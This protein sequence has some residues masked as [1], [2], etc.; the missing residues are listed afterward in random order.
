MSDN[1]KKIG[2]VLVVGGGIGGMQASL[3]LA[4]AGYKVYL[5]EKSPCIGGVMAQLDKTF[6][7]NDCAMCTLAPRIV[8]TGSHLNIDKIT[9]AQI[10]KISGEPGN[11]QV[12]VKKNARYIDL[13]KCTGCSACTDKCPV[14]ISSEFEMDLMKRK[15]IYR[16]YPQAV[17]GAFSIDKK[18]VSPCSFACPAGVNA[19]AYV[20]L[21]GQGRFAEA[22]EVERRKN[23]FP[24][25]C[26]RICPHPCELECARKDVDEAVSI[27]VLKRFLS[28][29]EVS[30]PDKKAP[31]PAIKEKRNEKVAVIGGGPAG[32]MAARELA[33]KGYK[34]TVFE[35]Q[36]EAG[37]MLKYGIPAYR[38]PK[39]VLQ[40]EIKYAVTD[41]GVE[42]KTNQALGKDFTIDDLKKQGYKAIFIGIG[43]WKGLKLSIPGEADYTGV[44]DAVSFLKD[45]N[46]NKPYDVKGKKVA[47]IGGGNVAIDTARS[48]WRLGADVTIVYSRSRAEMPANAWEIEDAVEE[49]IKIVYLAAPA[50][51]LGEGG[52]AAGLECVKMELSESDA[53]GRRRP[54]QVKGSEFTVPADIIIPA[55]SQQPDTAFLAANSE[56]KLNNWGLFEV[57]GIS[58]ETGMTGV[59]AGGDSV[60]GPAT[61]IEAV[62][63]GARAAESIHRYLTGQDL[64]AGRAEPERE[65]VTKD[66]K[67][68]EKKQREHMNK[69]PVSERRGNFKEVEL[70][71]TKEQ[72]I[73]EASRCLSCAG[74]CECMLCVAACEAKAINH[75]MPKEE[76]ISLDVGAV[77]LAPGFELFDA[78]L[79]QEFGFG[80]YPNV[81]SSLQFERV[82]S[83]SGPYIGQILR[84]SDR[85]HPHKIAFIQCVGSREVERNYCSSV[86]CMYAT[87]EAIIAKEHQ[88]DL[89]CHIFYIDIRAF[90]KGFE[91]YYE[92]AKELGVK[93]TRCR[94]SAVREDPKTN[95]LIV[96]YYTEG[97]SEQS[98]VPTGSVGAEKKDEEFD[99]VVLSC[100]LTPPAS[101]KKLGSIF[102][103][104]L[105][106]D[107]F[108]QTGKFTP[109]ETSRPGVFACGPFIEP[110]DIPE[111]VM[112]ACGAASKAMAL[113]A[114][115]RNTLTVK[116]EF[117]P[118]MDVI[119]QEPRIGVFVCH[120]GK[121][122]GGIADVP[123]IRDYAKTL[124]NVVH[125]EDSLYTCSSDTQ[126]KI[127]QMIKEH[128]LNRV[129]VASCTP[130]THEPLFRNTC[131]EAGLN[132]YLFE[133]ANIRD[134]NTWVHM[135]EPAKATRKAKDLVRIAIAKSRMLE[136]L[137]NRSLDVE[138]DALVIGGGLSGMTSALELANQGFTTYLVERSDELGG[139]MKHIYY[140]VE[141][142]YKPQEAL[143]ALAEKVTT[144]PKI[145][146]YTATKIKVIEG[147]MGNFQT[148]LETPEGEVK[149]KHGT[150]IVATGGH[151]YKPKEYLYGEDSM[152]ITQVQ[153]EAKIARK[154]NINPAKL[155]SKSPKPEPAMSNPD[156]DK[157]N[158]VVMI[159]CVGSRDEN[160]PYCSRICCT[161]AVKNALRFK[162]M[163]PEA[164]VYVLYRD[165]RTYGF[166]EEFYRK[167]REAGVIFL[168]YKDTEKPGVA[169]K[170]G[171]LPAGQGLP[172][173]PRSE[174]ERGK[175]TVTLND[176]IL[177]RKVN[178]ETDLVVLSAG[179]V[180][181]P[182]NEEL[183][184]KLKVPLNADKF[185]LEAHM[186]LRPV[187][188]ATEGVYLCGLAHSP[189]NIDESI[190]QAC[191][192]ASR[193]STILAKD[194]I[195]LDA[196]VS[197][198]IDEN[199]DGCAYC[200]DP[201]PYH[202]LTLIE[203]M[204]D[205]AIKKTIDRDLGICK[206]CGVCQ[207][208]CPK[209][210]IVVNNFKLTQL[211]EMVNA[212][213]TPVSD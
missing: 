60:S 84:A 129:V 194:K 51:V 78:N 7:T 180:P 125:V 56:I 119:G 213:L 13:S 160:H 188:F 169:R 16:R 117:P 193:A 34:V 206:G 142:E 74:C 186:K 77:V 164:P 99:M 27:M 202:A 204:K 210:G 199:C 75:E 190:V 12:T 200:V 46:Q 45:V 115:A 166:N 107:G 153:F 203:Y 195:E 82:M 57:D 61:V 88:P 211:I 64:K 2:A 31:L 138:H 55:I 54:V 83:A 149:F 205:G 137:Q 207:A 67:G 15:A 33:T 201:C 187:D 25:I 68:V 76:R 22:L 69:L 147:S 158:S 152:V 171:A 48:A 58:L 63:A 131:R 72:A 168:R 172:I 39:D 59:F 71:Y 120:C 70:G 90:G 136:P 5:T 110:K 6:P 96:T 10:E 23:P 185:F 17:P 122:I 112:E 159:Q 101:V 161:M 154:L 165:V 167:A 86:C 163:K 178:I 184:Q 143:A 26:G 189:K 133:M 170:N 197:Q 53:S 155:P 196:I 134:Q 65:K 191:G 132:P 3:D 109:V 21:A 52:K 85:K 141:E 111:T 144:H 42:L 80:R 192:A 95:N 123:S 156:L 150:V 128:N 29:W 151:E 182:A 18:G 105:N 98:G 135:N 124:P 24:S 118:E 9:D 174:A 113:L 36:A 8:D 81:L 104:D 145:K 50:K 93:Y 198:V 32:L 102:N 37:G 11:F 30:N 140:L 179:T 20:A 114:E 106:K 139:N 38:L 116:R 66:T 146:V 43:A 97:D 40:Q 62:E 89:E 19:H 1:G 94:P 126:Q 92:R 173:V 41:M 103:I 4:E 44:V 176:P 47:V 121:N 162:K 181:E 130:R 108:C 127:K 28:D 49:G 14:S 35:A 87:K 73:A 79:K 177:N 100:G 208:T 175:L 157:V 91:A 209:A 183:A 148:T 212:A